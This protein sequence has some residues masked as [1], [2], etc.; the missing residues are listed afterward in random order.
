MEGGVDG[1][2][3]GDLDEAWMAGYEHLLKLAGG[4]MGFVILFC[5]LCECFQLS[6]MK[7]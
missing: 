1:D 7:S 6:L 4:Y 2:M 5:F 3:D